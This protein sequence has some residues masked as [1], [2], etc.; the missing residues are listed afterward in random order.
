[1]GNSGGT[2]PS[3]A[4]SRFPGD[5]LT[6]VL[7]LRLAVGK[8]ATSPWQPRR[9]PGLYVCVSVI[10]CVLLGRMRHCRRT[11]IPEV[12]SALFIGPSSSSFSSS[13]SSSSSATARFF[14]AI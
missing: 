7:P 9:K 11:H 2:L 14:E 1:M 3:T 4:P 12:G 6:V 8:E 13:F 5:V 10:A